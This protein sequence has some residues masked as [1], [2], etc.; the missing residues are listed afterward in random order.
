VNEVTERSA[1]K[2]QQT[3]RIWGLNLERP[4]GIQE[5]SLRRVVSTVKG[6]SSFDESFH[7]P[8][9]FEGFGISSP[10]GF[11]AN[12]S[13]QQFSP[14]MSWSATNG[15]WFNNR[16]KKKQIR[17]ADMEMVFGFNLG[18]SVCV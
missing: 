14:N 11:A 1:H 3:S 9:T 12:E 16:L 10:S 17:F 15:D 6:I 8:G 13:H 18:L 4:Q 7:D 5:F 2:R